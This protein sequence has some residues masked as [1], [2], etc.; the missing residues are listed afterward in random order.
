[1]SD[2]N[3]LPDIN[4]VDTDPNAIV[5]EIIAGYEALTGKKLFPA[6]PVRL[7]LLAIG[8]L[9]VQQR[10][11]IN[12]SAKQNLLRYATDGFLD[13]LGARVE[14][15][16]IEAKKSQVTVRFT[17]S[18]VRPDAV[19]VPLGTRV[20]P[21]G[22]IFFATI[23]PTAIPSGALYADV[24]CECT[25]AGEI[26]NGFLPGQINIIV[27]PFQWLASVSN[28]TESTGGAEM[29]SDEQYRQ[30]IYLAPESF[31]VAGPD[32]AYEFW[33]KTA[34][35]NI[36]DVAVSS[37]SAGTVEIRPLMKDGALP[38]Q[39][40]LDAV[41]EKCSDKKVRPLTDQVTVLAPAQVTYNI[42]FTYWIG[43]ENESNAASIQAA[44]NTSVADYQVWQRSKLGRDINP[45][46][47]TRRLLNAGAKRV[48]ITSPAFTALT[49]TQVA[50]EGTVT[51]AYGG[52]EDA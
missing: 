8:N 1:M 48:Q 18:T 52:V 12:L 51:V 9:I 24:L 50:K 22:Q 26:G 33:A 35:T 32:G 28:T 34:D 23:E 2:L 31:S 47:L 30:R 3:S 11:L 20:S 29:E 40:V 39:T 38:T 44:V 36:I 49:R 19:T 21:D 5:N 15:P 43:K 42:D 45:S 46:E 17:L 13:H 14:T 4:F 41:L 27:D 6:D 7:F 10:V 25:Q 37:P 16:R